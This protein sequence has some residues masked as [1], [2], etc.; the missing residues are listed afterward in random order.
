MES[1]EKL[2]LMKVMFNPKNVA[3]IGATDSLMK[4]GSKPEI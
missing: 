4:I 3:V 1:E 2:N